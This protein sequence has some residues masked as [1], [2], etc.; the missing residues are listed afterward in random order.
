MIC[1]RVHLHIDWLDIT[2]PKD[3]YVNSRDEL[4]SFIQGLIQTVEAF[5]VIERKDFKL[6]PG[7]LSKQKKKQSKPQKLPEMGDRL[8]LVGVMPEGD[9]D[10]GEN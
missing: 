7:K 9:S 2:G 3:V 6:L 10:A 1:A 5:D 8:Y 4:I